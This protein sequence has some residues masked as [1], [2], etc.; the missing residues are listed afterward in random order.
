MQ[1]GEPLAGTRHGVQEAD[2]QPS[3]LLLARH[4]PLHRW[5]PLLQAWTQLRPLQVTDPLAGAVQPEQVLPQEL[6]LV[7]PLTTQLFPQR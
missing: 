3:T 6:V 1:V 4:E 2:P 5:Y 7:L